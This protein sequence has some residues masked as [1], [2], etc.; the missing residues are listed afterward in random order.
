MNIFLIDATGPFFKGYARRTINW[1][2]IP[3][4]H[5]QLDGHES[6]LQFNSIYKDME[7]FA[8]KV[9]SIGYNSVS[10]DDVVHLTDHA[11]YEPALREL[12]RKYQDRYAPVFEILRRYN[13]DIY[14]TMDVL[15][16][17][18]ALKK[19]LSGR[20]QD[21][22]T[23]VHDLLSRLMDTLPEIAGVILRI[24]ESDGND[25]KG[26][27]QSE[28]FLK[29]P[30]QVN[31]LLK[32]LLPLFAEHDRQLILRTWTVGAHAVGDLIW[33]R[34]TLKKVLAT[35]DSPNFILSMKYG[36]SDFF[37][38]LPLNKNFFRTD[39]RKIIELQ[40]RREY[41]G[42]GE[43][44]SFIGKDYEGFMRELDTVDNLAGISVWCQTGGW[45]PFKRLTFLESQ[46][47][48]NE[49]NTYAAL[50]IF[51]EKCSAR[52]ALEQ[53]AESID[54]PAPAALIELLE[55]SEEVVKELLYIPEFANQKL[56]FRRVRIPPLLTVYWHTV[57]INHS[58]RKIMRHFVRNRENC[59]SEGALSL[60]K[61]QRMKLLAEECKLPA[62]DI[63]YMYDT[64]SI[65][66]LA[67]QYY[68]TSDSAAVQ[69]KLKKAKKKYKK[70][71]PKNTR[72]RYRLKTDFHPFRLR[73]SHI[74]WIVRFGL[75]N[76]RGYRLVDHL[77]TLHLTG[78]LYRLVQKR[79]PKIFPKFARKRAMG[80]DVIF[81]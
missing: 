6:D 30:S 45:V 58:L 29:R 20:F 79:H 4:Q 24:G 71:Y 1:S 57:F 38:Y 7:T 35:I 67:R 11:W 13:L 42:C 23:F 76:Q 69:K 43:F 27:F 65:L 16:F 55:T 81:K 75:R 5:L 62:A 46:G 26:S 3:F 14:L 33:H 80:V 60:E 2:K 48:W 53:Y 52:S 59:I 32:T 63:Q 61:I 70:L 66:V 8:S 68:F 9:A 72:P 41:E 40:A 44:P 56:F 77:F 50:K 64:F 18:P 74:R 73:G 36:E 51:K 25:V 19:R 37:R 54:N 28:L 10:L 39:V 22:V 31:T 21:G 17:S 78:L 47:I 15:T 34:D 12:I 49:I